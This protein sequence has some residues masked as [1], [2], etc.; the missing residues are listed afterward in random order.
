MFLEFN[1]TAA[2][3]GK[4]HAAIVFEVRAGL[5]TLAVTQPA[6]VAV[7]WRDAGRQVGTGRD[8]ILSRLCERQFRRRAANRKSAIQGVAREL[9]MLSGDKR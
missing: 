2:I 6:A 8:V 5:A 1:R 3:A 4:A 7:V 9:V